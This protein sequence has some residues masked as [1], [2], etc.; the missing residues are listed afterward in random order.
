[1]KIDIQKKI[2]KSP[3]LLSILETKERI[4]NNPEVIEMLGQGTGNPHKG[5]KKDSSEHH[6]SN[7][8][9]ETL[10]NESKSPYN[11]YFKD[12]DDYFMEVLKE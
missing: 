2:R 3:L 6:S 10:L 1:M 11:K 5:Y 8:L 4:E 9:E 7:H 12:E